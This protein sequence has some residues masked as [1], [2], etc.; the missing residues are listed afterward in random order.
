MEYH[1]TDEET[2]VRDRVRHQHAV[3]LQEQFTRHTVSATNCTFAASVTQ[4]LRL[5]SIV[6]L[7]LS[8]LQEAEIVSEVANSKYHSLFFI[9]RS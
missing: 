5:T 7:S 6:R 1:S 2:G 8:F 4:K 9:L 3:W